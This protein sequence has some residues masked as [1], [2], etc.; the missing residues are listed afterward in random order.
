MVVITLLSFFFLYDMRLSDTFA[1]VRRRAAWT[2]SQVR[3]MRTTSSSSSCRCLRVIPSPTW[4]PRRSP[5][6]LPL[7]VAA[8]DFLAVRPLPQRWR[9]QQ[10]RLRLYRGCHPLCPV[11]ASGIPEEEEEDWAL[12]LRLSAAAAAL[13]AT[14]ARC[15]REKRR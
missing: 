15:Y 4:L 12:C 6:I 13:G 3:P 2:P 1:I 7:P 14:T 10:Q 8:G 5:R 11:T 9:Q